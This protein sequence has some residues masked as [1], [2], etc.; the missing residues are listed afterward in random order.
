MR[1]DLEPAEALGKRGEEA[2]VD[3]ALHQHAAAGRAGLAGVLHDG[4]GD[5]LRRLVQ[6]GVVE[7]DLRR[8]AAE[9]EDAGNVVDGRR[10]LHQRAD[11]R[12]AGEGDEVDAGMGGKRRA[13][14]LAEPGDN[15]DGTRRKAGLERQLGEP[16]HGQAGVLGRL[17]HR[18]V[19]GGKRRRRWC[20]RTSAP[21]SSTE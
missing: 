1:A 13:G 12:R 16:E 14:F 20:A 17:Q 7:D 5:H 9:L 21:D 15:V 8:L 4:V 19:A 2:V 6:V 10:L 18:R 3:R 11:L